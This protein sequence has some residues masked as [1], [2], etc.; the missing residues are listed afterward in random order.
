MSE[1]HD[2]QYIT[3]LDLSF[4]F[5]PLGPYET[6]L[7]LDYTAAW[8]RTRSRSS[9]WT[10]LRTPVITWGMTGTVERSWRSSSAYNLCMAV[11][12]FPHSAARSILGLRGLVT[13]TVDTTPPSRC[14]TIRIPILRHCSLSSP[15]M[16]YIVSSLYYQW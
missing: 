7:A 3:R 4:N 12:N 10:L 16:K 11:S 9:T 8:S 1:L 2:L 6:R 15:A 14:T 5:V 13:K